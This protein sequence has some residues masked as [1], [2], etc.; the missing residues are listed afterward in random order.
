MK[1]HAKSVLQLG[2]VLSSVVL[3][4][5][6]SH[7]VLLTIPGRGSEGVRIL[8]NS[9]R[10]ISYFTSPG[11]LCLLQNPL[12]CLAGLIDKWPQKRP[13]P[14]TSDSLSDRPYTDT[15]KARRPFPG[16]LLWASSLGL[17]AQVRELDLEQHSSS[18]W[19]ESL[20]GSGRLGPGPAQR[21]WTGYST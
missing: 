8:D 14:T 6:A 7:S 17:R 16:L 11:G 19:P 18:V 13:H 5:L 20:H 4:R 3:P 9:L 10:K 21:H 12:P 1:P 2:V 15:S